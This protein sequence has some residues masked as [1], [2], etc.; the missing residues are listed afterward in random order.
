LPSQSLWKTGDY[1]TSRTPV[2]AGAATNK[3]MIIGWQR[4][5]NGS[6]NTLNVDWLERRVL[7]RN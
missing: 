7:T 1:V 4:M 5:T 6:A 3:Y 2:Q